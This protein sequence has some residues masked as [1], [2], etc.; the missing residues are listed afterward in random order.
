M[1]MTAGI[2]ILLADLWAVVRTLRSDADV[3]RKA[4]WV[5]IV[6]LLPFVGVVGWI[7]FGPS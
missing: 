2:M 3:Q 4:M 6:L 5:G 1:E 7:W